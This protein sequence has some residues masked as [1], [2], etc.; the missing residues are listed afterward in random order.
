MHVVGMVLH[1]ARD[2]AEAVEAVLGWAERKGAQVLGLAAEISRLDCAAIG[3]TAPELGQRSDLLVSLV[4]GVWVDRLRR[5]PLLIAADLGRAAL[6]LAIPLAALLGAL[7][8]P[9]LVVVAFLL[10]L[11]G[12]IFGIAYQSFLP[13]LVPKDRLVEGN[14]RL[15]AS[16]ALANVAGPGLAGAL[17]QALTAPVAV[18]FDALSF[19]VSALFLGRIRAGERP[20]PAGERRAGVW[21]EARAGLGLVA[22]EPV[23]R[24]LTGAAATFN[25]FDSFLFAIYIIYLTRVLGFSAAA[26]GAVFAV[27]G[28]GGLLGTAVAGGCARRFGIGRTIAGAILLAGL[29]DLGIALAGG[30]PA[31]ALAVVAGAEALVQGTAVVFGVNGKSLRQ[32]VTPDRFLGRVNATMR[33]MHGGVVPLG[34]L[35]GGLV[36]ERAGVRQTVLLAGCGTLLAVLWVLGSPVRRQA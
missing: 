2:S 31:A 3:V 9:L 14:S 16:S 27:G 33:V 12:T 13:A 19:L 8:L 20:A 36:A 28:A 11:L 35:L 22:R 7:R 32:A 30:P 23:L 29:G 17:V 21:R 6:L 10:G 26:V 5:R 34:A 25:F 15:E 18:V 1:P 4:A 24:A